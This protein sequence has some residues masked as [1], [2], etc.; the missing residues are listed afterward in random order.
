V[1]H[2]GGRLLIPQ[3]N[4]TTGD[5]PR[6]SGEPPQATGL[7][8]PMRRRT[9]VAQR[10]FRIRRERALNDAYVAKRNRPAPF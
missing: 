6:P 3:W 10:A 9:C 7:M 8:M 1:T 5:L 4:T 2:P